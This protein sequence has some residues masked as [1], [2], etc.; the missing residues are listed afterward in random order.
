MF[1]HFS[2]LLD[3][4]PL[5]SSQD[6]EWSTLFNGPHTPP[7]PPIL[8]LLSA[9]GD[10]QMMCICQ[11]SEQKWNKYCL[12]FLCWMKKFCRCWFFSRRLPNHWA[13]LMTT[14]PWR[15]PVFFLLC[16]F[17][18]LLIFFYFLFI[19]VLNFFFLSLSFI[20]SF[21]CT[22]FYLFFLS[23]CYLFFLSVF[24]IFFLSVFRLL[25]LTSSVVLSFS[26]QNNY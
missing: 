12:L 22:V 10:K 21:Y 8:L 5:S 18:H 13:D 14:R 15:P 7:L 3:N 16:F 26:T 24:Y 6:I 23:L 25:F 9:R 2:S 1:Q 4:R 20:I 11:N 19:S 17:L